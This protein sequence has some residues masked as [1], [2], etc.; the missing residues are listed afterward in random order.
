MTRIPALSVL[1]LFAAA[2]PLAAA[3]EI[4]LQFDVIRRLLAQQLFTQEGRYYARGKPGEKCNFA[5]LENPQVSGN[6]GRLKIAAKFSGRS[7]LDM[8]GRCLGLG[9]SFEV[10]IE[11]LPV[12]RNGALTFQ[13]VVVTSPRDSFYIRRVRQALAAS[14]SRSF[15]YKIREEARKLL[16]STPDPSRWKQEVP[17]FDVSEIRMAKDAL[18]LVVDFQLTIK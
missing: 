16:E 14:F 1:L 5:Y 17:R 2:W 3:T 7:S 10:N 9:D 6:G 8:L 4:H 13:D 12:Y 18:V 11:A 15:H